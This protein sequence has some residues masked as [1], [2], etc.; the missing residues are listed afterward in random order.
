LEIKDKKIKN[1]IIIIMVIN[2]NSNFNR[3]GEKEFLQ[4]FMNKE[5]EIIIWEIKIIIIK[6]KEMNF[7]RMETRM[8]LIQEK[9][10]LQTINNYWEIRIMDIMMKP[11]KI[12]KIMK[13]MKMKIV[14]KI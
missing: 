3:I 2:N 8:N 4:T 14:F 12:M 1:R 7:I 11:M 10:F 5:E 13:I 6:M 9:E